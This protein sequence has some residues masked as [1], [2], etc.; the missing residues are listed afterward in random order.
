MVDESIKRVFSC[1]RL[2]C[3]ARV[4]T[5]C[6]LNVF[7]T[8]II[9]FTLFNTA[10]GYLTAWILT[11]IFAI[12]ALFLFS[13]P[14]SIDVGF[15]AIDIRCLVELTHIPIGEVAEIR[16][17]MPRDIRRMIPILG[18]YGFFGYYGFYLDLK[19]WSIIR[20]YCRNR[21][22]MVLIT[23]IDDRRFIVSCMEPENFIDLAE[24]TRSYYNPEA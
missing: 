2:D 1:G 23:T 4:I 17:I 5:L 22:K 8:I 11:L 6:S 7:L 19:T 10:G 9:I 3:R 24:D 12:M 14:R 21:Q 13:V 16:K 15:G 18:S 20:M